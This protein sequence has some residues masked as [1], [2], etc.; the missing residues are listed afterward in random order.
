MNSRK[1]TILQEEESKTNHRITK[2]NHSKTHI[3]SMTKRKSNKT[4]WL[5]VT[6]IIGKQNEKRKRKKY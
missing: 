2:E 1:Q 3:S 6:P 4:C 5:L